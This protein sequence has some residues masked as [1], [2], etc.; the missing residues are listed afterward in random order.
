MIIMNGY[1]GYNSFNDRPSTIVTET[2]QP[3]TTEQSRSRQSAPTVMTGRVNLGHGVSDALWR[4]QTE[5]PAVG[6]TPQQLIEEFMQWSRMTPAEQIREDFLEARRLT[7]ADLAAMS[8]DERA[9]IEN[10]IEEA[11]RRKL[12]PSSDTGT[13]GYAA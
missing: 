3:A 10:E 9:A 8:A 1:L 2:T 12:G 7:E 13:Y 11:I 4:L 6:S 5:P